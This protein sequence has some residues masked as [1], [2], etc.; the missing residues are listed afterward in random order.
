MRTCDIDYKNLTPE[1]WETIKLRQA[2]SFG[3]G[4]SITKDN[5]VDE[6]IP[7]I[8][9]GQIHSRINTGT[10]LKPELIRYVPD[11]YLV[12]SPKCLMKKDDLVFAD[13]SEDYAGIG[14]C[15]FV[16]SDEPI[17]AGYHSI[18]ARPTMKSCFPKYYAYLFQTDYWRS[19]IRAQVMGI[20]VFSITQSLLRNTFILVPPEKE[21]KAIVEFLDGICPTL[22]SIVSDIE[23]QIQTLIEYKKSLITEIATKGLRSNATLKNSEIEWLGLIPDSWSVKKLRYLGDLQ[24]GISKDAESFGSGFPFVSYGNVYN[25]IALPENVD[26]LVESSK[27]DRLTY[28]VK[29]GDV[30]FTRTSETI[31]EIGFASTCLADMKDAT[32]AGFLI[33]F[34]PSTDKLLPEYAKYYFRAEALRKYFVKEMMIVTRASLGQNLL[35]NLPVLLPPI[36]EQRDIAAFLDK[37]CAEIDGIIA[38]KKEAVLAMTLHKKSLIF[39]Y[40]TGKKRVKEVH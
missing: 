37:R 38:E 3:K 5:L 26:G 31:E 21:Q 27:A 39:E 8:S 24:N 13:T 6:G 20:K 19:Q 23:K 33:R 35:K 12:S 9:Y 25:N 10:G 18:I 2:F 1:G 11:S 30:F 29:R 4:L 16:D 15:A 34:R 7:V 28:S 17:F 36:D 40:V 22:D 14:N 32:F